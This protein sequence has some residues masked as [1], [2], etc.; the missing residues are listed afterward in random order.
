M[1]IAKYKLVFILYVCYPPESAG[2]FS[3]FTVGSPLLGFYA[4][5]SIRLVVDA[6]ID[7]SREVFRLQSVA[8]AQAMVLFRGISFNE[9]QNG[10]C[11]VYAF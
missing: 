4:N 3:I 8:R 7:R 10:F 9:L 2:P 6:G 11:M 1:K 5:V